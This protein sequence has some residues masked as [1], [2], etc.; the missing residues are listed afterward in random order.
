MLATAPSS[1]TKLNDRP[2]TSILEV[3]G[4]GKGDATMTATFVLGDAGGRM[5]TADGTVRVTI[6]ELQRAWAPAAGVWT[7]RSVPLFTTLHNVH[8]SDFAEVRDPAD[9]GRPRTILYSLGVLHYTDFDHRPTTT[10][11]LVQVAFHTTDGRVL[12]GEDRFNF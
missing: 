4:F 5:T 7:E 9:D 6:F 10:Q 3:D 11:G 2:P 12:K 1:C 8:R